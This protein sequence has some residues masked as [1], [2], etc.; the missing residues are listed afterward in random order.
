MSVRVEIQSGD[1]QVRAE[2]AAQRATELVM[3]ELYAA[4]QQSFTAQVWAWPRNLPTRKLKGDTVAKK[5][6]SYARGEGITPP[7]PRNLIDDDNLRGTGSWGMTG[8]YEATFK[9]SADYARLTHEGG[10]IWAWGRRPPLKG[11]RAVYLPPRPWTRAVLGQERVSG[12][13]PFPIA[14]RLRDVWLANLRRA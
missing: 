1:L 6:A 9:W 8:A 10:Y 2:Q 4:F 12:I 5:A 3:G 13:E 11:A 14:Q 7:N